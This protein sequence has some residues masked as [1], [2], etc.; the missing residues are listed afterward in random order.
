MLPT[1][2]E[3]QQLPADKRPTEIE[4]KING[5]RAL[6]IYPDW[7]LEIANETFNRPDNI[8]SIWIT[9]DGQLIYER[10]DD[11]VRLDLRDQRL[12]FRPTTSAALFA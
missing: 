3:L 10:K 11:Q 1:L 4:L 8:K 7:G 5:I 9:A 12:K 6:S 2:E